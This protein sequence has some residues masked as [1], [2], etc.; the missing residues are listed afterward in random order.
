MDTK[1]WDD[2][3]AAYGEGSERGSGAIDK[4]GRY[5]DIYALARISGMGSEKATRPAWGLVGIY[6][7]G[8]QSSRKTRTTMAPYDRS[9]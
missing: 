1:R 2:Q 3:D 4:Q 5:A 7:D 9:I 6:A 8:A